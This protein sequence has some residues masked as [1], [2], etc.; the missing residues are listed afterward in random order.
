VAGLDGHQR[1]DASW[2]ARRAAAHELGAY[3]RAMPGTYA[4]TWCRCRSQAQLAHQVLLS[5][6]NAF[7]SSTGVSWRSQ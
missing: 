2:P 7:R 4:G 5:Y 3:A 1:P 6:L